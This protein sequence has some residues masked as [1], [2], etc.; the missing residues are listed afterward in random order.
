[1]EKIT[2][3]KVPLKVREL[4]KLR[5]V[6]Y[7]ELTKDTNVQFYLEKSLYDEI[8]YNYFDYNMSPEED[9]K[10]GYYENYTQNAYELQ[11]KKGRGEGMI[12][13]VANCMGYMQVTRFKMD[14][15]DYIH[16]N[17]GMKKILIICEYREIDEKN[18]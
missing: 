1:M 5:E 12:V 10:N 4:G 9:E 14:R 13:F 6:I 16:Y 17:C 8:R 3:K 7:K 18:D 2:I 11:D 15:F